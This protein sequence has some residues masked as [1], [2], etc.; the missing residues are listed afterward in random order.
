V[1]RSPATPA[2][3]SNRPSLRFTPPA[4]WC[5][6]PNGLLRV[7]ERWRLWFQYAEDAPEYRRV[8]WGT[9]SSGD[10]LRWRFDGV[11][12]TADAGCDAYSGSVLDAAGV[13]TANPCPQAFYT[14]NCRSEPRRQTQR[15]ATAAPDGARLVPDAGAPVLDEGL[16]DFRDPFVCPAPGG[17]YTMLV[18]KPVPWNGGPE[19][20]RSRIALY[21]SDDL[22][23]WRAASEF[24]PAEEPRVLW[25]VPWLARLVRPD[26]RDAWLLAISVVDRRDDATHCGTRVWPGDFDGARFVPDAG[27]APG[28][29]DHGPD[30]YAP[31]P[32]ATRDGTDRLT[33]IAWQSSWAYARRLPFDGWAGGPMSLPR[34][35][36]LARRGDGWRVVQQP[37]VDLAPWRERTHR[38]PDVVLEHER[39]ATLP[40]PDG[41]Y[42][43]ELE[44]VHEGASTVELDFG[45]GHLRFRSL[46]HG[47]N[48][49]LERTAGLVEDAGFAGRWHARREAAD[50]VLRVRVILDACTC[51]IF[52]DDGA[53]TFSALVFPA[54]GHAPLRLRASG[55][56]ARVAAVV[57]ALHAQE[58]T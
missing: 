28:V 38:P 55:G 24:G 19:G 52:V 48:C 22:R 33:T 46:A 37:A 12:L 53:P 30:Y 36:R 23:D 56:A 54:D 26:G 27:S 25:E 4:H 42:E 17:G 41:P 39:V 44:I 50:A 47:A 32:A 58:A 34:E 6:D 21:R 5:N 8:H 10:L 13:P 3:S 57:H 51:E 2:P 29:L 20:A 40:L 14:E 16:A 49:E 43:L 1:S 11:A 7:G 35:L 45:A 31:I 9:A 15:S 18:A